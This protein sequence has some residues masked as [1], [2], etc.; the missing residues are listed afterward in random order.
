MHECLAVTILTANLVIV[1]DKLDDL[2]AIYADGETMVEKLEN[3]PVLSTEESAK[4]AK[5]GVTGC[6]G[7]EKPLFLSFL[8]GD[9]TE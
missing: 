8:C 7:D 6:H 5:T 2:G 1:K 3:A 4:A 9:E